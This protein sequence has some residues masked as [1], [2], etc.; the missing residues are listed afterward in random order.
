VL[1]SIC[2][3]ICS[4]RCEV[5]C[6]L[7]NEKSPIAIRALERYVSDFGR[8][9]FFKKMQST[10]KGKRIA[11]IGSGPTGLAAAAELAQK[12]YCPTIF[13]ALDKPGGVLRYGVP[14]FRMPKKVLD[15][16]INEIKALGVEIETNFYI[17]KTATLQELFEKGFSLVLLATGAGIPRFI[18]LPGIN[19]GG[20]YY[21]EEFLM[22]VNL[23]KSN[24]FSRYIP[25]FVIGEKVAVVGSGNTAL[26]CG[27]AAVR[28]GKDVT[29]IFRRTE[30]DMLVRKEERD[31]GKEEG[32]HFEPLVRPVKIL[33]SNNYSVDGLKCIRMDY[34]DVK[35]NGKWQII[36]V[37]DSDFVLDIDTVII[38]VGHQP[39][40]YISKISSDLKIN[41]DK[42]IWT[43]E[44]SLKTTLPNV[45]AAGNVVTNA[46][47]LINAILAGKKVAE[48]IDKYLKEA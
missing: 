24:I 13:E 6:V 2:G 43:E 47:P 38:A 18:D 42:T 36:P 25:T 19:L 11:I 15:G 29:V 33:S 34:A 16:E 5:A 8:T 22:R 12:G 3:R 41:K 37:P 28:L 10:L 4:A 27:R 31:Y 7:N 21:G 35:K 32:I 45:F 48:H 9:R 30:E 40:S 17:G 44:G 1:P 46:A 26:D 20:V 39:N 23:M 14:D